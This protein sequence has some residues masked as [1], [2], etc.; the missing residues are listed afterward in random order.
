MEFI[1]YYDEM[2]A[3]F[4]KLDTDGDRRVSFEEFEKGWKECGFSGN[5]KKKFEEIDVNKGGYV[6]F[7]EFCAALAKSKVGK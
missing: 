6:L 5:A 1:G 4:K 3:K 2:Y 7:D